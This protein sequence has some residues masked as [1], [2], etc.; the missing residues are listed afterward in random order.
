[1]VGPHLERTSN[2]SRIPKFDLGH[3]RVW[4]LLRGALFLADLPLNFHL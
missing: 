4:R 1:M 3:A 2:I